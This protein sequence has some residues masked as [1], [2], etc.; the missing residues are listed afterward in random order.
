MNNVSKKSPLR[1]KLILIIIIV[2]GLIIRLMFFN[3][4]NWDDDPDYVYKTY[5][6]QTGEKFINLDNNGFRIGTYY[7][8]ALTYTLFGINDLGC[9]S[10]AL[11]ISLLSIIGVFYLGKLLFNESTGLIASLLLSFYPLDVEL[12]SRL[13]PDGLLSGFSLFTIYFLYRGDVKNIESDSNTL[14]SKWSYIFCGLL[15]GWCTLVNMS[16]VVLI[17]YLAL[18]FFLSIIFFKEKLRK[19]GILKGFFTI[20]ALR[21]VIA[22][23]AFLFIAS[24]EGAS[25][26]KVT[27]DFL[28]KYHN[29][30]SH[31]AVNHGFCTDLWMFPRIMFHLNPFSHSLQFQGLERSYYGFYY[32][33]AVFG[34]I[35]GL[36]FKRAY[37]INLW[38]IIVFAYLQWGS[39]S[40]TEYK[41]MHR[42]PRHLSLA[43]PPMILCVA[44]FIGNLR[45]RILNKVISPIILS[46]LII[47]SL[48]FCYYRHQDLIDSVLPQSAI[49]HYLESL[50]PKYVY[51]CN[52]TIAYQR[53]LDK[54]QN[55]GRQYIDINYVKGARQ[56]D[57]FVIVG[58]FRN[59]Q[60]VV[61]KVLPNRYKIPPNWKLIDEIT[62]EGRLDRPPYKVQIYKLID[63]PIKQDLI[64]QVGIQNK[65]ELISYLSKEFPQAF[66][67]GTELVM[68]WECAELDGIEELKL[69]DGRL[70]LHHKDFNYPQGVNYR[71]F[72]PIP[73]SQ[74]LQYRVIKEQGRGKVNILEQPDEQNEFSLLIKV[75]DGAY[76]SFDFYRFF[77][78][79]DMIAK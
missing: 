49:N 50:K 79:A 70:T 31:Y 61:R 32:I 75:D 8:A 43:T 56:K 73:K 47:S 76:P 30:L 67:K 15:L 25:Y 57:A 4:L 11:L 52:N 24:I 28:F 10:Y 37:F 48:V 53:F 6:V 62:V 29:T 21:Y 27:G 12:A 36:F 54:F 40:F 66:T 2:L 35:F 19:I 55:R 72:M 78:V 71:V 13:M 74:S 69:K 22:V 23:A 18:Y 5:R 34:L 65:E 20:L 58:E 7:P 38:L 9:G 16:A 1:I 59:W 42:L 77:V 39:M 51:A 17:F 63:T 46:F 64:K 14:E 68:V 41:L 45:P 60:D 33:V 44:F 26:Y 3:G